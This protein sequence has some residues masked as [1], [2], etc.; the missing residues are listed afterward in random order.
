[1]SMTQTSNDSAS[2]IP[3]GTLAKRKQLFEAFNVKATP[4]PVPRQG[5]SGIGKGTKVLETL[6]GE[7]TRVEKELTQSTTSVKPAILAGKIRYAKSTVKASR[8]RAG[9]VTDG[10]E[11]VKRSVMEKADTVERD[12]PNVVAG[13]I[14][15]AL[16]ALQK[17]TGQIEGVATKTA[18][19]AKGIA[20]LSPEEKQKLYVEASKELTRAQLELDDWTGQVKES[21]SFLGKEA[22][23]FTEPLKRLSTVATLLS[24]VVEAC[25]PS[26]TSRVAEPSETAKDTGGVGGK[27]AEIKVGDELAALKACGMSWVTA[28]QTY[29]ADKKQ[30]QK[31]ADFRKKEVDDWLKANLGD[32]YGL[33][34]APNEGW[35]SVGSSDPT[36][37]YD[38]SINKHAEEKRDY[39]MVKEFNAWFRGKF[40]GEGGTVFDTNLYASAPVK[41]KHPE[42]DGAMTDKV[43]D[44]AALMKMRRY[45]DAGEFE[46]FRDETA[47]ACI[48]DEAQ[49]LKVQTQ[50]AMADSNYRIIIVDLLENG[51][52]ALGRRVEAREPKLKELAGKEQ[53]AAAELQKHEKEEMAKVEDWLKRGKTAGSGIDAFG[54]T[55]EGEELSRHIDHL[56]KDAALETTNDIYAEK[57]GEV[58]TQ[59]QVIEVMQALGEALGKKPEKEAGLKAIAEAKGKLDKLV[60]VAKKDGEDL[61]FDSRGMDAMAKALEAGDENGYEAAVKS[62]ERELGM[63]FEQLTTALV[64]AKYFAN[65]AYQS[66]GPFEHVV[67]ATQ[68][69]EADATNGVLKDAGADKLTAKQKEGKDAKTQVAMATKGVEAFEQLGEREKETAL[70][71]AQ[72]LIDEAVGKLKHE[73]QKLLSAEQC[74]QSFNEQLGDFLKDLEHYAEAEPGKAMIQSSKYLERLLDAVALMKGKDLFKGADGVLGEVEAQVKLQGRVK[75]ELIAARKGGLMLMPGKPGEDGPVDQQEQRRAY[76]C[77]FMKDVLGVTS[78]AALAKKYRTFAQKVNVQARKAMAAGVK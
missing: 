32:K 54:L 57:I 9:L 64:V 34:N 13:Q 66:D 21:A 74:L 43:N 41:V 12:I 70:A 33:K 61:G 31:L 78:L 44:L 56:L 14:R 22:G 55:E 24:R 62:F 36:S 17:T 49:F 1:M 75:K 26:L 2:V 68:A 51:L 77:Q 67:T 73:R 52:A 15:S 53:E 37:D 60:R 28:K 10:A 29:G 42:G 6:L 76:A 11:I 30:M 59:E 20:T 3:E 38:I 19:K 25:L 27:V 46:S 45:M 18:I 16:A 39:E 48:D 47:Q 7:L 63:R 8:E 71:E 23:S 4:Q 35:V 69:A 5:G 50:F 65:E 58:R 72:K 40:G